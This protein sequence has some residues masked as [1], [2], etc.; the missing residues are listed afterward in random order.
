[1]YIPSFISLRPFVRRMDVCVCVCVYLCRVCIGPMIGMDGRPTIR[2][3]RNP[4]LWASKYLVSPFHIAIGM[5]VVH[6]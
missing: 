4:T 2:G 3:N 1:M 5:L 6:M